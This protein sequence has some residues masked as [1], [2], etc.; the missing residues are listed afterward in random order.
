MSH[1]CTAGTEK[2]DIKYDGTIL[3]CPAFKEMSVEKMKKYGINYIVY[4]RI[5]KK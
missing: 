4:M 1:L 5:W 3:P 2:L